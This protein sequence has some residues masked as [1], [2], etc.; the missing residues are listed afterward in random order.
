MNP[1]IDLPVEVLERCARF[2]ELRT[3]HGLVVVL[4]HSRRPTAAALKRSVRDDRLSPSALFSDARK[5]RMTF[6]D[7][8]P[9]SQ[10]R[11]ERVSCRISD[12]SPPLHECLTALERA[13]RADDYYDWEEAAD[14]STTRTTSRR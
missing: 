4:G 11:G 2:G 7:T 12:R 5:V 8:H 6:T 13:A 10:R 9:Y 1:L 14:G 3:F